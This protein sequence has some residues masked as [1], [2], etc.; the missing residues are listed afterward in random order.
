VAMVEREET[1]GPAGR[2]S[3]RGGRLN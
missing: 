2:G 3:P 1:P